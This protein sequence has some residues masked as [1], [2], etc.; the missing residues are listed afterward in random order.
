MATLS[1]SSDCRINTCW[2]WSML[3]NALSDSLIWPS[4]WRLFFLFDLWCGKSSSPGLP[5]SSA[6]NF[7]RLLS[8]W[9]LLLYPNFSIVSSSYSLVIGF[10][11]QILDEICQSRSPEKFKE[12]ERFSAATHDPPVFLLFSTITLYLSST[13]SPLFELH[14]WSFQCQPSCNVQ[15]K[16]E[17]VSPIQTFFHYVVF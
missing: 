15:W 6:C 17:K 7:P 8:P 4:F 3:N 12:L 11:W 10:A 14:V 2:A 13:T 9:L 5:P 1:R 16:C